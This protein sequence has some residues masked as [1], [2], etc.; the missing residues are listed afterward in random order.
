MVKLREYKEDALLSMPE[1]GQLYRFIEMPDN[2][3]YKHF[4]DMFPLNETGWYAH[5]ENW[6]WAGKVCYITD[7]LNEEDFVNVIICHEM[8]IFIKDYRLFKTRKSYLEKT[9]LSYLISKQR[10]KLD[11]RSAF[12]NGDAF[13]WMQNHIKNI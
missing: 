9:N 3:R 10:E 7:E 8:F 1:Y 4:M 5:K 2:K 12:L 13:K 11:E 6:Y